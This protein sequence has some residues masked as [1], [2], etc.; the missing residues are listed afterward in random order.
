MTKRTE[1]IPGQRDAI[2]AT[3][4]TDERPPAGASSAQIREWVCRRI[5]AGWPDGEAAIAA[6][7][8]V[9][10]VREAVAARAKR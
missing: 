5:D 9:N 2:L 1:R 6:G 10:E 3:L 7:L 8:T 4:R